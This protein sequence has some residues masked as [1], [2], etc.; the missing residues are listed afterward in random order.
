MKWPP[1]TPLRRLAYPVFAVPVALA[2][3]CE[4]SA[5]PAARKDTV[6]NTVPPPEST[7]V[8]KPEPSMWDSAAGPALFIAGATPQEAFVIAPPYTDTV[9]IDST[10]FDSA[11]LKA[12]RVDL[13]AGGLKVG[14]ARVGASVGS[15]R[16]DSCRTWPSAHLEVTPG[17]T[18]STPAWS[19]A[20]EIG[21]ASPVP[22]DSIEGLPTPDSA[23]LAADVAR[24][25]SALPG[26]TAAMFRGLPFVVKKAWRTK[27][28]SGQVV[29]IAVVV[30]N[31]NQEANPRQ[32][33]ILLIAE[34]DS[35]TG[36][37]RYRPVYSERK[38]GLEETLETADPIAIVLL[39]SE[40]YPTIV[41]TRD[42][43]NGLSYT[44]IQRLGGQWQRRW[45][46]A[47]AGC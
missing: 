16:T 28:P 46:S 22:I 30:R 34:R 41:V 45:A 7:I 19:V 23:R 1:P 39:G 35:T 36:T 42:A 17:D 8:T 9:A 4:R 25:S 43:G 3:A 32:E 33:R 24:L 10:R 31:V 21:R 12:L 13:F 20:F 15:S 37:A 26:D 5:P 11:Q 27:I 44:F 14:T 29:L 47:Y 38:S 40:R 18:G 2:L 6:V